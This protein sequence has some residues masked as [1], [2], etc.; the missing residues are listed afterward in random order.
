VRKQKPQKRRRV[1]DKTG[2]GALGAERTSHAAIT[3]AINSKPCCNKNHFSSYNTAMM[4]SYMEH[5]RKK[6]WERP[7]ESQNDLITTIGSQRGCGDRSRH[8]A[9]QVEGLQLCRTGVCTF[10]GIT[11]KRWERYTD[12]LNPVRRIRKTRRFN[13]PKRETMIGWMHAYFSLRGK[14]GG[15]W[16]P[17]SP[18]LHI[19]HTEKNTIYQ[20][21]RIDL[22]TQYEISDEEVPGYSYFIDTMNSRFSHVKIGGYK[23]FAKCD[24]CAEL[25][26]EAAGTKDRAILKK[27]RRLKIAHKQVYMTEKEQYW[28]RIS[29]AI[30]NPTR[31][32]MSISD[33]MEQAKTESPWW[34]QPPY[35]FN[36]C[37]TAGFGLQGIINHA[38]NPKT[39][40]FLVADVVR[41]GAN[42]TVEWLV[43]DLV[44]VCS[45]INCR[46]LMCPVTNLFF[47]GNGKAS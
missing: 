44:M 22:L 41:K 6:F 11:L 8:F 14:S 31:Y 25:D 1:D 39:I 42:F 47:S 13:A 40:A 33:G 37:A 20:D 2:L 15:D 35:S 4:I 38:H 32:I 36:K 5:H 30:M 19:S 43:R 46:L 27:V 26:L 21:M 18:T 29:K 16:M 10:Y 34:V 23:E 3:S 24:R 28:K 7:R 17:D 12:S 9:F 45:N